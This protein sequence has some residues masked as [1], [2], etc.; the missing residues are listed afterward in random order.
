MHHAITLRPQEPCINEGSGIPF[1]PSSQ[2]QLA[3]LFV[4]SGR[5][6][7]QLPPFVAD[8]KEGLRLTADTPQEQESRKHLERTPQRHW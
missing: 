8:I 2:H 1:M 3:G 7:V 5:S 4:F 6:P